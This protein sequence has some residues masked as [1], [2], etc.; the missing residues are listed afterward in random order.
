MHP[1]NDGASRPEYER[2]MRWK[3]LHLK[4]LIGPE[5][6]GSGENA[7]TCNIS[8]QLDV[9]F[10]LR[11]QNVSEEAARSFANCRFKAGDSF[12]ALTHLV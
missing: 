1:V 3:S 8:F 2:R 10:V 11:R 7:T 9:V 6:N 5:A 4:L 12:F